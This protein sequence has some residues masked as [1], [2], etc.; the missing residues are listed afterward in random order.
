MDHGTGDEAVAVARQVRAASAEG[1]LLAVGREGSREAFAGLFRLFAPRLEGYCRKLGADPPMAQELTQETML[2]VWR[3]AA[4]FDPASGSA[5][6]W[7]FAVARNRYIDRVRRELR[8][9]PDPSDPALAGADAHTPEA[10]VSA[11]QQ[12]RVLAD[13]LGNLPPDQSEVLRLAYFE[14][15]TQ[16]D[17][18]TALGLPL[19]TVKTRTRLGLRRLRELMKA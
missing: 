7:I 17:I 13:A 9:E 3:K 5:T 8:P 1:L 19:G 4:T 14:H 16:S 6:G 12:G 2:A 10:V 15:R 11:A 18:A